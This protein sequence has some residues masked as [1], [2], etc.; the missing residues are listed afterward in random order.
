MVPLFHSEL[1][2]QLGH[3]RGLQ[4]S[5]HR[6]PSQRTYGLEE[7]LRWKNPRAFLASEMHRLMVL[8][9]NACGACEEPMITNMTMHAESLTHTQWCSLL[10]GWEPEPRTWRILTT[11]QTRLFSSNYWSTHSKWDKRI[12]HDYYTRISRGL[13][14]WPHGKTHTSSPEE[15]SA[16]KRHQI[17]ICNLLC[18][19]MFPLHQVWESKKK[20]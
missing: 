8:S 9:W 18:N 6:G 2:W 20:K 11:A 1:N 13:H 12:I 3:S 5:S 19:Q 4:C 15:L 17:Y 10:L 7:S 14:M 16:P